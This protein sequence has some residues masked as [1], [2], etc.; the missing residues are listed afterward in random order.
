MKRSYIQR[1]LLFVVVGGVTIAIGGSSASA[2]DA[3]SQHKLQSHAK[4][5]QH[6]TIKSAK[7]NLRKRHHNNNNNNNHN[8]RKLGVN[9]LCGQDWNDANTSCNASCVS[10]EDCGPG[11]FCFHYMDCTPKDNVVEE[12]V[13]PAPAPSEYQPVVNDVDTPLTDAKLMNSEGGVPS[14]KLFDFQC[15]L[16]YAN[17]PYRIVW[18]LVEACCN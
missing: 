11:N 8:H 6:N 3:S 17:D 10:D 9:S 4:Q 14:G 13:V 15:V 12:Q 18:L 1:S 2:I 16:I 5:Q 7:P